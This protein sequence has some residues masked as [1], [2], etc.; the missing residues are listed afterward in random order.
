[1]CVGGDG[2]VNK[3]VSE[4]LTKVQKDND[5]TLKPGCCVIRPTIPVGIIPLGMSLFSTL[6]QLIIILL[7]NISKKC[8]HLNVL[9]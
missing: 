7:I 4:L 6:L 1:M 9:L 5:V 3:V 2:T 8:V